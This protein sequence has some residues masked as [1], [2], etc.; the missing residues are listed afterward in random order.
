[1]QESGGPGMVRVTQ[2]SVG[3]GVI[4]IVNGS[5][6]VVLS[7]LLSGQQQRSPVGM[8]GPILWD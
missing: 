6:T 3:D 4:G 5:V 2:R 7:V 1:M 8:G